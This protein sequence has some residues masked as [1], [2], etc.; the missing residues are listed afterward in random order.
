DFLLKEND[1]GV[2]LFKKAFIPLNSRATSDKPNCPINENGVPV[3]PNDHSL[4]F[5][6]VGICHENGRADRDKWICPKFIRSSVSSATC[7]CD[8]PCTNAKFGRT[9]YTTPS[10]NLRLY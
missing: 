2:A 6:H 1:D 10:K 7:T 8:N 5:K 9:A 4:P 3:C